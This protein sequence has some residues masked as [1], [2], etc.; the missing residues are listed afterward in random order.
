MKTNMTR[1]QLLS[2]CNGNIE[3]ATKAKTAFA[4]GLN[5]QNKDPGSFF[6]WNAGP[7]AYDLAMGRVCEEIKSAVEND[8]TP[9]DILDYLVPQIIREVAHSSHGTSQMGNYSHQAAMQAKAKLVET[10]TC[11]LR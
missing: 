1:E 7:L 2:L 6:S 3:A 4:N 10:M 11:G 8:R 9:Q 5:D